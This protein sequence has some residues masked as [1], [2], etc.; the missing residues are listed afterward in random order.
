M[1]KS[2]SR[3]GKTS[4]LVHSYHKTTIS[5]GKHKR[6]GYGATPKKSQK[7]AKKNWGRRGKSS[8]G[9][10]VSTACTRALGLPDDCS[11]LQMLRHLR[12]EFVLALPNG[13]KEIEAYY[14]VA[15]KIIARI[16]KRPDALDFYRRIYASL[17]RPC[18][19]LARRNKLSKAFGLYKAEIERLREEIAAS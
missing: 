19:D 5:D 1:A 4:D 18:A 8:S 10:L 17:V 6:S 13:V 15:P 14:R 12:D 11:E 9:C 7:S 16:D 3:T 2:K